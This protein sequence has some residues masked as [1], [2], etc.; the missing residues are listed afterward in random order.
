MRHLIVIVASVLSLGVSIS[1]GFFDEELQAREAV[2][3]KPAQVR[4]VPIIDGQLKVPKRQK[5]H[6]VGSYIDGS[7]KVS[8]EGSYL[9]KAKVFSSSRAAREADDPLV[10]AQVSINGLSFVSDFNPETMVY[11]F[12]GPDRTIS[13]KNI[14]EIEE[15]GRA[16][17]RRL[18]YGYSINRDT[19]PPEQ[20]LLMGFFI[21]LSEAP[22]RY[23]ITDSIESIKEVPPPK[24][25][26]LSNSSQISLL[27]THSDTSERSQA[28]RLTCEEK[29][30]KSG[31][32]RALSTCYRKD[33]EG[34]ALS[35]ATKTRNTSHDAARAPTASRHCFLTYGVRSGPCSSGCKGMC[36]RDC[37]RGFN[38]NGYY[39]DCLDHDECALSHNASGGSRDPV[40]GDEWKEARGDFAKASMGGGHCRRCRR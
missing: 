28:S 38:T 16:L 40:C 6:I 10:T 3:Q 39:K 9:Q 36:G 24:S 26:Y 7:S 37:N 12:N 21:Y 14:R 4:S 17:G 13:A 11:E 33:N 2:Q 29:A 27:A 22:I 31:N 32:F 25:E 23:K 18:D 20:Q 8:F 30:R 5:D 19:L 1:F 15:A 35:C 34:W